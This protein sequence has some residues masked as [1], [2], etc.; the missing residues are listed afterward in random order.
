[1]DLN[2][3]LPYALGVMALGCVFFVA[4]PYLNGSAKA[5]KRR[6]ALQAPRGTRGDGRTVDAASRRKQVADSLKEVEQRGH[7]RRPSL[8]IRIQQAGLAWS[9][10]T[11]IVISCVVGFMFGFVLFVTDQGLLIALAGAVVGGFGAPTWFLSFKKKRRLTKFQ[12]D[13]PNAVD[14]I[15]RGVKAGLPLADCLRVIA[16]E[17]QEPIKSEFRRVVE[18]QTIGL[19]VAEACERMA[20]RVPVSEASFFSIVIGI[21]QKAGGN[22]TEALGNLSRVIRERKKMKAKV[23]AVSQEAKASAGIIGALPFIVGGLVYLTSPDYLSLLWTT[24]TGRLV[25]CGCAFWMSCGVF[26]MKKMINFDF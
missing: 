24:S 5:E 2:L 7:K 22:L 8:E 13:F 14:V 6:Q 20:E 23:R 16:N 26:V 15:I 10:P 17:S 4:S 25:L 18:A 12:M 21:Q 3:I 19:T 1:M 9:K 11:Y